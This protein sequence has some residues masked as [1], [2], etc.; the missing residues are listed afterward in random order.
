MLYRL[1]GL[2]TPVTIEMHLDSVINWV[3]R[4]TWRLW[5]CELGGRNWAS[6]EMHLG[7][8]QA[9]LEK[10]LESVDGM[11]AGCEDLIHQLVTVTR[12]SVNVMRWLYLWAL[13]EIWLVA[14][15]PV[16]R[17]AGSWSHI[18]GWTRNAE[19]DSKPDNLGWILLSV[20]AVFGVCC[21]W[22][23][24]YLVY[25][26]FGVCCI[27][28]MLYLVDA[29]YGVCCMRCMLYAVYAVCGVCC[30]R[31]M[32]YAVYAVFSVCCPHC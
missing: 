18:Q 8:D 12:N 4:A 15:D 30:M 19:T 17:H 7:H 29:V 6:L 24:L 22:C 13:I 2:C 26:V 10:D 16:R 5:S 1:L 25:S 21:I 28:C 27:W 23:I 14:V 9:Q 11:W 3:G 32:L 20:D 31:C